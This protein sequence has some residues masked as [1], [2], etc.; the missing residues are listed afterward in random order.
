MSIRAC[1]PLLGRR[2][3]SRTLRR[4]HLPAQ[5]RGMSPAA[6]VRGVSRPKL[7]PWDNSPYKPAQVSGVIPTERALCRRLP[8]GC[9]PLQAPGLGVPG[10]SPGVGFVHGLLIGTFWRGPSPGPAQGGTKVARCGP[11]R[12]PP[13]STGIP[14]RQAARPEPRAIE[15]SGPSARLRSN[16][17]AIRNRPIPVADPTREEG[18]A[19]ARLPRPRHRS[20]LLRSS[21]TPDVRL[22]PI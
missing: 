19:P 3:R 7:C 10:S 2:T 5:P 18:A 11:N 9:K 14:K 21:E 17:R 12:V 6:T 8:N 15:D 13:H 4:A 1:F 16:D 20:R 22:S